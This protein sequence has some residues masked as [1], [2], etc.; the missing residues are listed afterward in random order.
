[1]SCVFGRYVLSDCI[2]RSIINNAT[3]ILTHTFPD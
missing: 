3:Q 2:M 1:V